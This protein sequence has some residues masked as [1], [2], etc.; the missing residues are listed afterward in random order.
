MD[1]VAARL[2]V[3]GDNRTASS[4]QVL[5]LFVLDAD[6]PAGLVGV[7]GHFGGVALLP[8]SLGVLPR[9]YCEAR[10]EGAF[11]AG[12]ERQPDPARDACVYSKLTFGEC[13]LVLVLELESSC[14]DG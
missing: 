7:E 6:K 4:V 1:D 11:V 12:G 14:V 5:H 3:V 8:P 13:L 2:R 10:A 9:R